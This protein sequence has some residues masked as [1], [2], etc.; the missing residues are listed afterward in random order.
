[1]NETREKSAGEVYEGIAFTFCKAATVALLFGR[2]ALPAAA[3]FCAGFF[4]V[5][6]AKGARETRCFLGPPLV[7]AGFWVL[8]AAGWGVWTYAREPVLALFGR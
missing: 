4:V 2:Y 3:L 7:V 5:A 1:M 6:Y 8:V